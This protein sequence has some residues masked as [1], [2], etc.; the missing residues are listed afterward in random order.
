MMKISD[1]A[2]EDFNDYFF[3][4]REPISS[5]NLSFNQSYALKFVKK[6]ISFYLQV[7]IMLLHT[8]GAYSMGKIRFEMF[9]NITLHLHP[10]SIFFSHIFTMSTNGKNPLKNFNLFFRRMLGL[11][12]SI[13]PIYH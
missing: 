4:E 9:F 8:I 11:N 1:Q 6:L 7:R 2:I 5:Q 13:Y 12:A 3:D 10:K